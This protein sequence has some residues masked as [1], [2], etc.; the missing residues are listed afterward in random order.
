MA[1]AKRLLA[2]S[3]SAQATQPI[4]NLHGI[5]IILGGH[6]HLYYVSKG[7]TSWENYDTTQ[8]VLGAED[9]HGDILV[10]KSG[11][12]FRD[13]SEV[14]LQLERSPLGSVRSLV[15]KSITGK[16]VFKSALKFNDSRSASLHKTWF[17]IVS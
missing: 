14:I 9:D 5:D 15:I 10:I 17:T 1:L 7:I 2:L 13:L 11:S 12:D 8:S 16:V 3:P 6:D 4:H